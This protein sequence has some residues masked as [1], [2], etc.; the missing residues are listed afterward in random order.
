MLRAIL[1]FKIHVIACMRSKMEYILEQ[2]DKGKH[3]PQKV[4]MAPIMYDGVEYALTTVFDLD[5][6]HQALE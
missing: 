6:S 5:S 1:F 4:G 2:N 3:V